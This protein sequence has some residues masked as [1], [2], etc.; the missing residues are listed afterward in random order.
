[1]RRVVNLQAA[2]VGVP[3]VVAGILIVAALAVQAA[4]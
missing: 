1:L 4:R 2:I 3:F